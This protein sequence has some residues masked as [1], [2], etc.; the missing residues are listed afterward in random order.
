VV[1]PAQH[2]IASAAVVVSR[3]IGMLIGIAALSA[4]GLYRFNQ[5]LASLPAGTGN[6]LAE[7][8]A[9]QAARV[10]TAYVMQYGEIFGITAVVCIIGALLGLLISGRH[11]HADEPASSVD[12]DDTPTTLIDA[13]TQTFDAPTQAIQQAP[14][15]RHRSG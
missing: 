6:N 9:A 5:H 8:L 10:R 3:M 4:W 11:E 14:P 2:G 1:P 7:R 13:P 15:G 12:A